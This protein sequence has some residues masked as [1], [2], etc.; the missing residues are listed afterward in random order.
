MGHIDFSDF[1]C[2][3]QIELTDGRLFGM[4]GTDPAYDAG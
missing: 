3:I 4:P 2:I 1:G